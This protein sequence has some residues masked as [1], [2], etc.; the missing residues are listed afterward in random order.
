M[1]RPLIAPGV[2]AIHPATS[3]TGA[4]LTWLELSATVAGGGSA[5]IDL[6]VDDGA[7]NVSAALERAKAGVLMAV[8]TPMSQANEHTGRPWHCGV[9]GPA[10]ELDLPLMAPIAE[11]EEW[12]SALVAPKVLRVYSGHEASELLSEELAGEP[13]TCLDLLVGSEPGISMHFVAVG[14]RPYEVENLLKAARAV[15]KTLVFWHG[16]P[17]G[18]HHKE[19]GKAIVIGH[20]QRLGGRPTRERFPENA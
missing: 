2:L 11:R 12:Y 17:R 13:L 6:L 5:T 14:M 9:I 4:P 10:S 19:T 3:E 8:V 20:V 7:E 16:R 1:H 18:L 15:R